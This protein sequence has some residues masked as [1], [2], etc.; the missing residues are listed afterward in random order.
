MGEF[1]LAPILKDMCSK[2]SAKKNEE[3]FLEVLEGIIEDHEKGLGH[4]PFQLEIPGIGEIACTKIIQ[5][6]QHKRITYQGQSKTKPVIVKLYYPRWKG[7]WNW[8]RSEQGYRAF[9]A[10]GIPAPAIIFSGYLPSYNAYALVIEYLEGAVSLDIALKRSNETGERKALLDEFM[11][12]IALQH[13]RGITQEDLNLKNFMI[14]EGCIY[15]IDGDLVKS[16]T[17]PVGKRRSIRNLAMLFITRLGFP[18][19]DLDILI[20]CYS[21]R[22]NWHISAGEKEKIRGHILGIRERVFSHWMGKV[23]RSRGQ[24]KVRKEKNSFSVYYQVNDS[25]L[26]QAIHDAAERVLMVNRRGDVPMY[27]VQ[28]VGPENMMVW[29]SRGYGPLFMKRSWTACKVWENALMLCRLGMDLR[30]P[31]ALVL[32]KKRAFQWNCLAFFRAD[33]GRTVKDLLASDAISAE[34]PRYLVYRLA[35]VYEVMNKI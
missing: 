24:L 35:D 1:F 34:M 30:Q 22:R 5:T 9:M 28:S 11:A 17:G 21:K 8:K 14:R 7:Y 25:A 31:V 4:G 27:S 18:I 2:L 6:F 13:E 19:A 32:M 29:H 20:E 10:K 16:G 33:K 3:S 23:Y 26:Y 12:I 15:S